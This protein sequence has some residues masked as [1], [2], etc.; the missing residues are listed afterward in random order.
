MISMGVSSHFL[1]LIVLVDEVVPEIGCICVQN[2]LPTNQLIFY[3]H[4]GLVFILGE[5][6]VPYS[7]LALQLSAPIFGKSELGVR[8][9]L[10]AL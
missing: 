6:H 8:S 3:S 4:S 2:D 10:I 5:L 1:A 7:F 9:L